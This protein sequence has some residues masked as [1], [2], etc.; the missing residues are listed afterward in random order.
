MLSPK[1]IEKSTVDFFK[2]DKK[3]DIKDK[4][5]KLEEEIITL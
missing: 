3:I 5:K 4:V 2:K 1:E